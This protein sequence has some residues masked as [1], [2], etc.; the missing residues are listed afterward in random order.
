MKFNKEVMKVDLNMEVLTKPKKNIEEEIKITSSK[1]VLE[2]KAVQAIRNAVKEHL[3]FIGLDRGNNVRTVSLLALGSSSGIN[4]DT[5][6]IIR[7]ALLS[8]SDRVILVHNH[9]SNS[10]KP[11]QCDIHATNTVNQIL[12]VFNVELLDHIIVTE[13]EY[14]SMD[15]T[16]KIDRDYENTEIY[17]MNKDLLIEENQRLKQE[18]FELQQ[19]LQ[20]K[21]YDMDIDL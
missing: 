20:E 16:N 19:K 13:K 10:T 3:L 6:D 4:I 11:S 17:N 12:K 5:K 8:A 15:K 18:I 14:I 21:D 1:N 9:P 2:L 7:T